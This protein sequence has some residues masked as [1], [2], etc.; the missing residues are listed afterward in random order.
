MAGSTSGRDGAE[1]PE[2][3]GL[4]RLRRLV[5]LLTATLI[6]GVI[7][8]VALLVI[9]LAALRPAAPPMLP[10]QIILPIGEQTQAVTLGTG[11]V[12]VVTRDAAGVE[13]LRVLD[14]ETGAP[15]AEATIAPTPP[16]D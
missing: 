3:P 2:P 14:A 4:R 7:T 10:A 9:R 13:R 12:A 6:L 11:W 16:A 5:T 15:R 1:T 8:V